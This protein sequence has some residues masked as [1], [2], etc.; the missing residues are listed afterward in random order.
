M[1]S[2]LSTR[3]LDLIRNSKM[4]AK[5]QKA[6]EGNSK[7]GK[8]RRKFNNYSLLCLMYQDLNGST[9]HLEGLPVS[10]TNF[11]SIL[12]RWIW[13]FCGLWVKMDKDRGWAG[14]GGEDKNQMWKT[15]ENKTQQKGK[16]G[17]WKDPIQACI[18]QTFSCF[19]FWALTYYVQSTMLEPRNTVVELY[20]PWA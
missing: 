3:S 15:V 17:I 18:Q 16:G 1:Q 12:Q 11:F 4:C 19:S 2:S 13:Q 9:D 20:P 7:I 14:G 5:Q 6:R 10:V 8:R